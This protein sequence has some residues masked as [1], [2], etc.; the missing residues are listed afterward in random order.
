MTF[1]VSSVLPNQRKGVP[2]VYDGPR[3]FT[4]NIQHTVEPT[5]EGTAWRLPSPPMGQSIEIQAVEWLFIAA[6]EKVLGEAVRD[7]VFTWEF[8][9]TTVPGFPALTKASQQRFFE[10]I[11]DK[12]SKK[13]PIE[14]LSKVNEVADI[15]RFLSER[16]APS[17]LSGHY[18]GYY[19]LPQPIVLPSRATAWLRANM[20][21]AGL[22][23]RL[24]FHVLNQ[25]TIPVM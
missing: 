11:L 4:R 9:N 17:S 16:M 1:F 22:E 19:A 21:P 2:T 3:S 10:Q 23:V 15:A 12:L 24:S 18:W 13:D 25:H 6:D 20:L 7:I 8:L 5:Q 14:Q